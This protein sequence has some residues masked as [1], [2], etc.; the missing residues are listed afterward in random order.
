MSDDT[1]LL[2]LIETARKAANNM[3]GMTPEQR[4]WQYILMGIALCQYALKEKCEAVGNEWCSRHDCL[5][6]ECET[7][8]AHD[9]AGEE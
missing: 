1:H 5:A 9:S 6:S 4:K 8:I 7:D 3:S 2:T